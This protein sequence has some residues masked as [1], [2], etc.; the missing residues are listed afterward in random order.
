[1]DFF[2]GLS[3]KYNEIWKNI[4]SPQRQ[5]Y[6]LNDLGP[7]VQIVRNVPI[8]RYD[9]DLINSR[10]QVLRCTYYA[11]DS[12]DKS[13][14][15][16]V[17]YL[18]GNA[19]SR[20]EALTTFNYVLPRSIL[21]CFD[22]AGA[23][24]SDGQYVTLGI[25]ESEDLSLVVDYI[26]NNIGVQKIALWGRSM[27]ASTAI[28]YCA[29]NPNKVS[30]M[31]LD[32]GFIKLSFILEEIGKQRTKIPNI[33]VDAVLHFI[34]NK[35]KNV[36]NMDIFQLDLLEQIK[37]INNCEGIIFCSAQNDSI[38][39]SYHTQKLFETY[40][41]DKKIIKFEGDHNTLRPPQVLQQIV[42]FLEQRMYGCDLSPVS[43]QAQDEQNKY[44]FKEQNY[45]N[46][47]LFAQAF[48]QIPQALD[49]TDQLVDICIKQMEF[50]ACPFQSTNL[51][52]THTSQDKY[53]NLSVS[54]QQQQQQLLQPESPISKKV[55]ADSDTGYTYRDNN[56][57]QNMNKSLNSTKRIKQ[58]CTNAKVL[59]ELSINSFQQIPFNQNFSNQNHIANTNSNQFQ[60]NPPSPSDEAYIQSQFSVI[61]FNDATNTI[62]QVRKSNNTFSKKPT[63]SIQKQDKQQGIH[64]IS[65]PNMTQIS[66][67]CDTV[68]DKKKE[69]ILKRIFDE[70][71]SKQ[72]NQT[73][74]SQPQ[75]QLL[76]PHFQAFSQSSEAS[77]NQPY[78]KKEKMQL[79][80]SNCAMQYPQ[81]QNKNQNSLSHSSRPHMHQANINQQ[82]ET[83]ILN[84]TRREASQED[85]SQILFQNRVQEKLPSQ[86]YPNEKTNNYQYKDEKVQVQCVNYTLKYP[87]QQN[88][89]QNINVLNN[90]S[91]PLQSQGNTTYQLQ[92]D[93]RTQNMIRNEINQEDHIQRLNQNRAQERNTPQNL[94]MSQNNQRSFAQ[95]QNIDF[96]NSF[97]KR[98][99]SLTNKDLN[100]RYKFM[101]HCNSSPI[102]Y[103]AKNYDINQQFNISSS[104]SVLRK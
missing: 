76:H 52:P 4:I 85:F 28:N 75:I 46:D 35:I 8:I 21:F 94:T 63:I 11:P 93:I 101:T 84:T 71:D 6:F 72:S 51:T 80:T 103:K 44:Q 13:K 2:Q 43:Y 87:Q 57:Y 48:Q 73:N 90:S 29:N 89:A 58:I 82:N 49:K 20:I 33:L 86:H 9:V 1:M 104:Q 95:T 88:K 54:N 5:I 32:S 59:N 10:E 64:L 100:D 16:C 81:Q 45:V 36:L 53:M 18:H 27:G 97:N 69:D 56:N 23:G 79:S 42:Q 37:K 62:Q 47:E 99:N 55:V 15:G 66:T 92:H 12:Y 7:K 19:S 24:K 17:I 68:L 25:N 30:V 40:R 60:K 67:S 74:K 34:K 41:G 102:N 91:R 14:I 70:L 26:R 38:I 96:S 98:D 31:A 61:N 50:L 78:I 83:K 3:E 77:N 65:K 39:N 22:F